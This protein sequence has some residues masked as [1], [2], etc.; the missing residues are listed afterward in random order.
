MPSMHGRLSGICVYVP[1]A[2]VSMVDLTLTLEKGGG[3]NIYRDACI[4]L[5]EAAT[6]SEL[7]TAMRYCMKSGCE[8]GVSASKAYA[9]DGHSAIIDARSGCQVRV[10]GSSKVTTW[11]RL[12]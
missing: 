4:K 8:E 6:D 7:R 11:R 1:T 12:T 2:E 10:R 9:G 5:K 3:E